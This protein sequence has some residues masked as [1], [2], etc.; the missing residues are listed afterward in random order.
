VSK[1]DAVAAILWIGATLYAVFGGADFGAGFWQLPGL[2][3]KSPESV[4]RRIE[5]SVAPVWEANHVWLVFILVVLWTAFP[6]AFS[7]IFSTLYIP[8][9]LAAL[10]IVLRGSAFA[11]GKVVE[12]GARKWAGALFAVSSVLTPFFMGTVVGAIASG[13]VP[14]AGGGD[15]TASWTGPLPLLVGALFVAS[16]AYLAAVFLVRDS[17]FAGELDNARHFSRCALAAALVAGALAAAGIPVL[18]DDA[19]FVYDGLTGPGLPLVIAS[20]VCG[21]L[22]LGLLARAMRSGFTARIS[23]WVRPAAVGAFV[24]VIWGS[25]VAQHPYLL[26]TSLTISDAAAPAATLTALFAVFGAAVVLVLPSLA[27][28]Y[29]LS[30]KDA[31]K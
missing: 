25:F 15:P 1:P 2:R 21:L 20:G 23:F 18:H 17:W 13:E 16:G 22:A 8:L 31:L 11:F 27:L 7:A 26:P 14:A 19:R 9:A 3:G 10:G 28:L 5:N 6:D 30:Q 4:R 29:R 24:A 12:G